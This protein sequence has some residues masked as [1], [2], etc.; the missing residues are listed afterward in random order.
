LTVRWIAFVFGVWIAVLSNPAQAEYPERLITLIVA[1]P[2]GGAGDLVARQ[3]AKQLS[4]L[5]HQNIVIEN[6]SGAAGTIAA[7]VTARAAPDGYTLLLSSIATHGTAPVVYAN[8]AYDPSRDFSHIGLI[9]TAPAMLSVNSTLPVHSVADL[10]TYARSKPGE[11]NFGSSGNG[12]G[13]QLWGE[14]FMAA[15]GVKLTHVPYK[16][17]APAVVD[18]VAG[19]IQMMFDAAAAQLSGLQTGQLRPL[20]VMSAERS[21][22]FPDVPT[23]AEAGYPAVIANLWYG[24]SGPAKLPPDIVARLEAALQKIAG[25]PDFQEALKQIDMLSTPMSAQAYS[26]FILDEND[27]YRKIARAADIS[28]E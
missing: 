4:E 15:S 6:R 10:V 14:M 25:T 1:V 2:P 20:A 5:L 19:R 22:F 17:S 26:R 13:P 16:G 11:L 28:V 9:A 18:L 8:I 21:I 27:K 23:M 24:L 12:S 3:F 7:A